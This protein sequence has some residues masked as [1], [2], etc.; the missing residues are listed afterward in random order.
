LFAGN[1]AG[2]AADTQARISKETHR[3]LRRH[4]RLFASYERRDHGL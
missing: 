4:W 2:F 1:L 3:C